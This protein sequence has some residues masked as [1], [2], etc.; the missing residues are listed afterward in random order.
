MRDVT[1]YLNEQKDAAQADKEL[2]AQWTK[3]EE[4]YNKKL[5]H[6]LTLELETL[7]RHPSM[8]SGQSLVVLYNNFI[9]DFESK[10]N[11]LSLVQLAM[12]IV[13]QIKDPEE[14]KAFVTKIGEIGSVKSNSEAFGLTRVLVGKTYLH[15]Q[16]KQKE[17]KAIID[18]VEELLNDVDG[19]SPVH[20]HYYLL[21]SDLYKIQGR[22][23]E[24]YRSSLRYLGCT[25]ISTLSTEDKQKN[26]FFLSLAALLGEGVYNF[27]EL[28]AHPVLQ[29]LK[30]TE[31][32]WLI[33]LLFAFNSGDVQ[34]FR[35]VKNKWSTQADLAANENLLFE[36]VC[37]LCLM[38]MTFRR[39]ATQRQINFK[40]ISEATTL[41]INQVE[42]LVMKALSQGLV[43]GKIDQVGQVVHLTW[44]QAR[45]LNTD[46]LKVMMTKINSWCTAVGDMERLIENKAGDILTF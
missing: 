26:A 35:S 20:S 36:K 29:T 12:V 11:P 14:S 18:E 21:A 2:A 33:D 43:K 8:Q 15:Q 39:E 24:F 28:L 44:V 25:D 46:Q 3:I 27:G 16:Q 22:H 32:E 7:V 31:N 4:L 41:P 37:L 38:E 1:K 40:E 42:L 19:V 30:G 9:G 45:V 10:M 17:T 34:K 23:A 6:Q 13:E 5:W